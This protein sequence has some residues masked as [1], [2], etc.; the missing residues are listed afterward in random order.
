MTH[1]STCTSPKLTLQMDTDVDG[2]LNVN[3][4]LSHADMEIWHMPAIVANEV[5][6]SDGNW[7]D[8]TGMSRSPPRA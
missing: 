2:A 6:T 8:Y 5:L 4:G 3:G 1:D 7:Y